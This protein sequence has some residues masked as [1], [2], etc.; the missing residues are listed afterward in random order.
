M[1]ADTNRYRSS[2]STAMLRPLSLLVPP[3]TM[4]QSVGCPS[5]VAFIVH[6]KRKSGCVQQEQRDAL[7]AKTKNQNKQKKR[8]SR[9]RNPNGTQRRQRTDRDA[10]PVGEQRVEAAGGVDAP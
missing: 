1:A 3:H 5:S 6:Q 4:A 10:V 7:L 2:A 9:P 8:T